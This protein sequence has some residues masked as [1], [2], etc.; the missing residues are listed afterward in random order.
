MEAG[1]SEPL[2]RVSLMRVEHRAWILFGLLLLVGTA[3][4]LAWYLV[5]STRYAT[6]EIRTADPVSG[7]I[8][9]SPV[10]FHGVEVGKVRRV[11]LV[12]PRSVSVLLNVRRDAPVTRATVA[13]ITAR[14]LA[15]RGF[16][17]YVY[18][19]LE[20]NG[21]DRRPL[22]ALPGESY[23]RISTAPSRSVS[24]DTTISEVKQDVQQ[25]TDLLHSVLD[26]KTVGALKRSVDDLQK[27]TAVL[28]TNSQRLDAMISSA[29]RTTMNAERVSRDVKPLLDSSQQVVKALQNQ[30]LPETDDAIV[31]VGDLATSLKEITTEI[32]RNPAVLVR[33]RRPPTPGPGE[34]K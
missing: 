19:A 27:V 6:F 18:V 24:L 30:I 14:G 3:G 25:L 11:Q 33:G 28:A 7:L 22:A 15:T 10:E 26:Q 31:R 2:G 16:T 20:N 1:S 4:G 9:D 29:E 17:G 34:R 32:E 23:P 13:T 12:D 8:T 21:V 5:A